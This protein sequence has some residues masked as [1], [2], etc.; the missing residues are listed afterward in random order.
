M[1]LNFYR[2]HYR[3]KLVPGICTARSP[4]CLK[5]GDFFT[6]QA[7]SVAGKLVDDANRIIDD[8]S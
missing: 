8:S 2:S 6:K 7:L 1:S 3:Q 5:L 4:R